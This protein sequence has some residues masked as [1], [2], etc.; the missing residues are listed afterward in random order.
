[1]NNKK[2][3]IVQDKITADTL[4]TSG[5]QLVNKSNGTYVFM[6]IIP[7][8]FNFSSVDAKKIAYTDILSI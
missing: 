6:N 5:F 7:Q 3:I 4:K 8:N 2:F 1:M